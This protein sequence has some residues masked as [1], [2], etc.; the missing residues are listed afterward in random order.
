[1]LPEKMV[2]LF[3]NV[4]FEADIHIIKQSIL[5]CKFYFAMIAV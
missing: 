5:I 2:V 1:M 4:N 3:V